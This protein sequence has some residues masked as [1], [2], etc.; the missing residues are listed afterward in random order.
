MFNHRRQSQDRVLR[1]HIAALVGD[2][3]LWMN[4]YSAQQFDTESIQHLNVDDAF[5]QEA[6][7]GDYCFVE[8]TALK[9]YERW[10]EKIIVFRWNR[11]YPADQSFDL[12]LC[13]IDKDYFESGKKR[14]EAHQRQMIFKFN[15]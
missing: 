6:V 15:E 4:H 1:A 2:D 10:I 12:D 9:P 11:A 7:Q 3:R 13:E 8:D 14:V 5:L